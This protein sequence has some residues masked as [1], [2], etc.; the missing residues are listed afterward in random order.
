[1]C[2]QELTL[3]G[4]YGVK[5]GTGEGQAGAERRGKAGQRVNHKTC[6]P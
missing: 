5:K 6:I 4:Q 3:A 2:Q 1:M